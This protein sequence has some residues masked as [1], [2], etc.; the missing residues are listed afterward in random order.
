MAV[1]AGALA[2]PLA[3]IEGSGGP[4]DTFLVVDVETGGKERLDGGDAALDVVLALGL[5]GHAEEAGA[6]VALGMDRCGGEAG[7]GAEGEGGE[8]GVRFHGGS[9]DAFR[10]GRVQARGLLDAD[11]QAAGAVD[12]LAVGG[13]FS[14][15]LQCKF[16]SLIHM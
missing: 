9:P 16:L 4:V 13:L 11:G 12:N 10:G 8:K 15:G 6:D 2:E 7:G 14:A 5:A 1:A 3:A